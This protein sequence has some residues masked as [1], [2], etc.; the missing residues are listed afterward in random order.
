MLNKGMYA[1]VKYLKPETVELF[2]AK[3]WVPGN[4][5]LGFDMKS[6]SGF[7][8]AGTLAGPRTYGHTGFT[9]TSVWIDPDRN[10]AII[11]LTNRTYPYRGTAAGVGRV[12][13]A[14]ADQVFNSLNP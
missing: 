2:T 10:I 7:S 5:A 13:A 1:G 4:R 14:V 9:G 3:T 11:V 8:S 12:R 6:P